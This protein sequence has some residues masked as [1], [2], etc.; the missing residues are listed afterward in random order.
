MLSEDIQIGLNSV[1]V[2]WSG[3]VGT[4]VGAVSIGNSFCEGVQKYA[5]IGEGHYHVHLL[6]HSGR[7]MPRLDGNPERVLHTAFCSLLF[8][9][10]QALGLREL[11]TRTSIPSFRSKMEP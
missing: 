11:S 2:I 5:E 10:L 3:D 8:P 4:G 7:R 9:S 6:L 1:V